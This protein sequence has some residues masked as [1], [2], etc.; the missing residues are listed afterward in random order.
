M[1]PVF[2]LMS[3]IKLSC[4]CIVGKAPSRQLLPAP[5]RKFETI[6]MGKNVFCYLF[7]L[8][9]F[10]RRHI[11]IKLLLSYFFSFGP[12]INQMNSCER[13][14]RGCCFLDSH[15][16]FMPMSFQ[17]ANQK[18]MR[19][20]GS[21][22]GIARSRPH[23]KVVGEENDGIRDPKQNGRPKRFIKGLSLHV[24]ACYFIFLLHYACYLSSL[25]LSF[26]RLFVSLNVKWICDVHISTR[27]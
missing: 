27:N 2:I 23:Y 13:I 11:P 24:Y 25:H 6:P 9:P 7:H 8:F 21:Y 18:A 17:N 26:P 22:S 1:P 3:W 10:V 16:C 5:H 20:A 4:L 19:N 15:Y 14:I 12:N